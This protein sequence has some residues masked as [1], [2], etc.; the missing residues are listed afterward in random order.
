[1]TVL[2]VYWLGYGLDD[3]Q[4][5][6]WQ[7]QKWPEWLGEKMTWMAW[8]KNDL[9]GL[10]KKWPEWLGEKMTWKAWGKNDLNGLGKK[11]PERLRGPPSLLSNWHCVFFPRWW[12]LWDLRLPLTTIECRGWEWVTPY[13]KPLIYLHVMHSN[14]FYLGS[15]KLKNFLMFAYWCISGIQVY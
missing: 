12:N 5:E 10:G 13:L 4:F 9:N 7:G 11:W 15:W 3:P 6:S 2:S 8:G 14:R 1:M